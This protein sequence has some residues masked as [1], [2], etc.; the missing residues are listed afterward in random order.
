MARLCPEAYVG[1]VTHNK[2]GRKKKEVKEAEERALKKQ[3][4]PRGLEK[5]LK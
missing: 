5:F 4:K 1:L 2:R 3:R